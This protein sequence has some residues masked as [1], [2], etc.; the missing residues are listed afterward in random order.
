[1]SGDI[2]LKTHLSKCSNLSKV[3]RKTKMSSCFINISDVLLMQGVV[4]IFSFKTL[5]PSKSFKNTYSSKVSNTHKLTG[6]EFGC[7]LKR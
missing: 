1:M 4:S 2:G 5:M 3:I 6:N 7:T